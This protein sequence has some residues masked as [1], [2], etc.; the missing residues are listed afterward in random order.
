MQFVVGLLIDHGLM[1]LART[2]SKVE[3]NGTANHD[4]VI[5]D[6]PII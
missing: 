3:N 1:N 2:F 6:I 5:V 4:D